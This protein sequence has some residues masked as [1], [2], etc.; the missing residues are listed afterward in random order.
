MSLKAKVP[1]RQ[2]SQ[3]QF[4]ARGPKSLKDRI[5]KA[6]E[7][8]KKSDPEYKWSMNTVVLAGIETFLEMAEEKHSL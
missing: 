2:E 3:V 8:L 4:T 6:I 1:K 5:D 7:K